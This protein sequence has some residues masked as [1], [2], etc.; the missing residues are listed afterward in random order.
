[1][2]LNTLHLST[3]KLLQPQTVD[4]LDSEQTLVIVFANTKVDSG[5]F[6]RLNQ[7]FVT[8]QIIGCSTA[9]QIIDELIVDDEVVIGI[10]KFEK[11]QL[12]LANADISN[13]MDSFKAGKTLAN[14]LASD[15]LKA[16][17]LISDGLLVNGSELVNGVNSI[18]NKKIPVTGGL[19]G[20][21][22]RFESTWVICDGRPK[23]G[24]VTAVGFYG[25]HIEVSHGSAGGWDKF[26]VTRTV[27]KAQG[28][29]LYQLD[30]RP[31]LALYK[32]YLGDRA[33]GLP[34]TGL[35]FPLSLY[36]TEDEDEYVVRTILGVDEAENSLTFAGD[37]P[38]GS[39]VQ[40]MRANFDRLI[41]GAN[42]SARA[43]V[44][45]NTLESGLAI[46][47]SCV[48]RRLV[49]GERSEEELEA[50]LEKLPNGTKQIGF[51]SYGEISP[52]TDGNC[53]LHNQTMTLTLFNES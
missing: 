33:D 9:G 12:K 44:E 51:Y 31:A 14:E 45:A 15:S 13:A 30:D 20:D 10:C 21:A 34:S 43:L 47:I 16:I 40:L 27:T 38:V 49:L 8:S 25:D 26:G 4:P 36:N 5:V 52:C 11:T 29:V 28:N 39:R 1:M 2:K 42:Q 48:G 23:S 53:D 6:D 22:D 41:D 50:T 3:A 37:I 19:A 24:C 7:R 18:I 32:E 35:L 17:F 46:A